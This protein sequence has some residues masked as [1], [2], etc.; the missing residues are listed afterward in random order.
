MTALRPEKFESG[1]QQRTLG[2]DG[3]Q[4]WSLGI[5]FDSYGQNL[6]TQQDGALVF[7]QRFQVEF[8]RLLDVCNGVL[9]GSPLRL[10]PLQFGTPRVKTVLVILDDNACFTDH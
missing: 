7:G 8:D 2:L 10:A 9:K 3:C 1:G 6:A 5:H 4:P